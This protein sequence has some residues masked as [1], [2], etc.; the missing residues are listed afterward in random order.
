MK[1]QKV[2]FETAKL[3]KEKGFDEP[4]YAWYAELNYTLPKRELV[5]SGKNGISQWFRNSDVNG[6]RFI[7]SPTQSLLQKYL[8]EKYGIIVTSDPVIG[9]SYL[10]YSYNIYKKDNI[11]HVIKFT[12]KQWDTYEEALE[13]GLQEGLKLIPD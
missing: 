3:A 12:A 2:S 7:S 1:E 9:L 5:E 8:R 11:W 10:K 13:E 6:D 4:T